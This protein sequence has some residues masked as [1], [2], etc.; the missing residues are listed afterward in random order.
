MSVT[1]DFP[2]PGLMVGLVITVLFG[3][4]SGSGGAPAQTAPTAGALREAYGLT[5]G[6]CWGYS[7]PA[8]PSLVTVASSSI[9]YPGRTVY[10]RSDR[11]SS[12]GLPA[13]DYFDTSNPGEVRLVRHIEGPETAR[14]VQRYDADPRPLFARFG[15]DAAKAP[16][17]TLGNRFDTVAQPT[18]MVPIE[19]VWTVSS[20]DTV[21]TT[22]GTEPAYVLEYVEGGTRSARFWL[23]VGYGMAQ[24]IDFNG[25]MHQ[26]CKARVCTDAGTC[27]GAPDC[28]FSCL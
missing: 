9:A 6:S 11:P 3:G 5:S 12:G 13:Q 21:T 19:H 8:G 26:V 22:R 16:I 7:S 10:V 27:S 2:G 25:F 4:C 28:S 17:L 20:T 23:V 18:G 1:R 15:L 14:L 24:Y